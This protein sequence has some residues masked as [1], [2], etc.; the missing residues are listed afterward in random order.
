V[1]LSDIHLPTL[2]NLEFNAKKNNLQSVRGG[3]IDSFED[4]SSPT[5]VFKID[6]TAAPAPAPTSTSTSS[7]TVVEVLNLN[8]KDADTYPSQVV[9]VVI[10]AD[11]VYDVAILQM[12]VPAIAAILSQGKQQIF[13]LNL[14]GTG[15]SSSTHASVY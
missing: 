10:G 4:S 9:D 1:Y 3:Q 6:P 11:L 7:S 13:K 8:W 15:S 2:A 12:L 5:S 14:I